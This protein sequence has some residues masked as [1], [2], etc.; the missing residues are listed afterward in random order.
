[1]KEKIYLF[2]AMPLAQVKRGKLVSDR[3][4]SDVE[5]LPSY[6]WLEKEL[7]FYPLFLAIG[8][9]EAAY[10]TG[11]QNQWR[12]FLGHDIQP[13]GKSTK[14]YRKAGEFPNFVLFAFPLDA[15]EVRRYTDYQWWNIVLTECICGREVGKGMRRLLFK[16]S[17]DEAKWRRQAAR[18]SHLVQVLAP[19]FDLDRA[20]FIWVRNQRTARALVAQ[21]FDNVRV[22]RLPVE[23][24]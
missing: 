14:V 22:K 13:G 16:K 7:G 23:S 18:D 3:K 9:E 24:F 8:T 5:F 11:Y 10:V 21:G 17:W 15:V 6:L 12:R 20:E 2:H 1:M 4:F 19:E